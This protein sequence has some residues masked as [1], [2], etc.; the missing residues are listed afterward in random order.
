MELVANID[1]RP[2]KEQAQSLKQTLER[3]IA[4]CTDA[5]RVGFEA[6][7]C[8]SASSTFKRSSTG[9]LRAVQNR[10]SGLRRRCRGNQSACRLR[11]VFAELD[12]LPS[13]VLFS[14]AVSSASP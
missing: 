11:G 4:A 5:S 13:F 10:G 14:R 6:S 12:R 1:L 3:C 8:R 7:G 9:V 2:S